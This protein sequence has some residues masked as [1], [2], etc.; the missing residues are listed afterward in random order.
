MDPNDPL[1]ARL[2][3]ATAHMLSVLDG[4]DDLGIAL[5]GPAK[6]QAEGMLKTFG[7]AAVFCAIL[8]GSEAA[9]ALPAA[10]TLVDRFA[11]G[12]ISRREALLGAIPTP[13]RIALEKRER[14]HPTGPAR[15][16]ELF[17]TAI[18]GLSLNDVVKRWGSGGGLKTVAEQVGRAARGEAVDTAVLEDLVREHGEARDALPEPADPLP[19]EALSVIG[20][21]LAGIGADD[22]M[23]HRVMSAALPA[24]A[25]PGYSASA[26]GTLLRDAPKVGRNDPCPCGSGR[27]FKA[28]CGRGRV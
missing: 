6:D 16:L 25:P 15:V 12:A 24:E 7:P 8:Q 27:K 19:V 14:E 22:A 5:R 23:L 9:R 3:A 26:M 10:A 17:T 20:S 2:V 18:Q 13:Q 11:E 1:S 28:C 4:L 21:V